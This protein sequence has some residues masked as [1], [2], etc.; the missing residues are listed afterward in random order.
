MRVLHVTHQYR[1]ALGGAEKY[2]T[3]LSEEMAR[4]GHQVDVFT[5]RSVD[6]Q[7]W[8]SELPRYEQ[9]DG[10]NVYRFDSW[11]RTL[12]KWAMMQ[13]G[14]AHYWPHES[15]L[16]EPLIFFGSGPVCPS[17]FWRMLRQ[18]RQ[19]D[20]VHISQLHYSHAYPA[21]RAA[22]QR[23]VPVVI[24]PHIHAEQRVTYDIGYLRSVLRGSAAI[25]AD[26]REE[27]SF[28]IERAFNDLVVVGGV[29]VQL[30]RLPPLD[31]AVSRAKFDLPSGAFVIL[32]LGRKVEYKG[33]QLCVDAFIELRRTRPN[34]YLLAVGPESDFSRALWA[35]TGAVDGLIV[36]DMVS[37]EER[38]HALN[39]CDVLALPSTGEAFGIVYLEAWAYRKPVIGANIASVSSLIEDG[40]DGYLI[41]PTQPA[42]LVAR[43]AALADQRERASE[44]G[45]RGRAKLE[46][47]YTL[48]HIGELV[49]GTYA[50]VLRRR[51]TLARS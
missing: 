3:D 5:T 31:R 45:Q 19:Y 17:M 15:R 26:T 12:R 23:G 29:G 21:Y 7:T 32:F 25:L 48:E 16:Y 22:R 33:I 30:D 1:P 27:Q 13:Y 8:R 47:R 44:M 2:I 14:F 34:V 41:D 51:A 9:L 24:T 39:A 35:R 37:D 10:V 36:R 50:R 43:L 38:L 11:P 18:A 6:Y 20:L 40:G 42:E 28:L 4:R 49:E 46:R